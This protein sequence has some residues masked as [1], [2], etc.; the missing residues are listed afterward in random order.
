MTGR[1]IDQI[2]P[3]PGKPQLHEPYVRSAL[4][5]V[6]LA[7]HAAGRIARPV[8]FDY[9]WGDTLAQVDRLRPDVRIVNLETSVTTSDEPWPAKGI[10]Y[11]M[12]PGNVPCLTAA[13]IDCCVLANNHV[14][15]WGRPGLAETLSALHSAGIHTSGAGRDALE[16][17]APATIELQDGARVLVVGLGAQ[18]SGVP[19]DW[20]ATHGRSGINWVGE[21]TALAAGTLGEKV[22]THARAGDV[23][24]ASIHWG[25]N[26]GFEISGRERE[27]AHAL[28]DHAGFDLVHGHSSH[29]V[30][31]IEIYRGKAILYGCGDLL[32]DYEGIGGHEHYR[33][34]LGLMYFPTVDSESG[35]I[36]RL[37]MM[38]TR[39]HRLRVN[40]APSDGVAWLAST[41]DRECRKLGAQVTVQPDGMLALEW[42]SARASSA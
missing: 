2:L 13:R 15:D 23:V 24:V 14:L 11:R 18:T 30:R 8:S 4:A 35:A 17:E 9:I 29:H 27:F 38:P 36:E 33:G 39:I 26:W 32:N 10:N 34:D 12:H 21:L 25:G 31:G 22:A 42:R 40:R 41:M 6:E 1:G 16:A 20:S 19:S 28:I 3:H 7:E 5:Y 37:L